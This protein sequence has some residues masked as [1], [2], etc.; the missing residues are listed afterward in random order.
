[1]EYS[2]SLLSIIGWFVMIYTYAALGFNRCVGTCFYK[3]KLRKFNRIRA[4]N[5][6]IIIIWIVSICG[7]TET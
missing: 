4:T 3:T 2:I 6:M 5:I 1:M 7:G